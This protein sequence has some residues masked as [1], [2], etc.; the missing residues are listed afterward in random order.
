MFGRSEALLVVDGLDHLAELLDVEL[1]VLHVVGVGEVA[2]VCVVVVA[3]VFGG[4]EEEVVRDGA[5]EL[6]ESHLAFF[7]LFFLVVGEV[8]LIFG[9]HSFGDALRSDGLGAIGKD[10]LMVAREGWKIDPAGDGGLKNVDVFAHSVGVVA[11]VGV[12]G[13]DEDDGFEAY[14]A[15]DGGEEDAGIDAVGLAGVIDFVEEA[16][17]LHVRARC[18]GGGAGDGRVGDAV[19][20]GIAPDGFDLCDDT[21]RFVKLVASY[22]GDDALV[23]DAREDAVDVGVLFVDVGGKEPSEVVK[24]VVGAFDAQ[25]AVVDGAVVEAQV[26]DIDLFIVDETGEG[27]VGSALLAGAVEFVVLPFDRGVEGVAGAALRQLALEN[28]DIVEVRRVDGDAEDG[29]VDRCGDGDGEERLGVVGGKLIVAAG[30]AH[31]EGGVEL[32]F[33][34]GVVADAEVDDG[35][36][37]E[38]GR[39]ALTGG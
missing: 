20:E 38:F 10:L 25:E 19:L 23:E 22:L 13:L 21:L 16:Y 7:P 14:L 9:V 31:D 24:V 18:W 30:H 27:E 35:R 15:H 11:E 26:L 36:V 5:F 37:V 8:F 1:L 28:G 17:V 34:E 3:V 2:L 32:V 4:A 39:S 33:E 29:I 12:A 6:V